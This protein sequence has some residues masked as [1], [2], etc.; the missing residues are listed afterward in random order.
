M[1]AGFGVRIPATL[2]EYRN[3]VVIGSA[4]SELRI[5]IPGRALMG[6]PTGSIGEPRVTGR[7]RHMQGSLPYLS[8]AMDPP[9]GI[10]AG[11]LPSCGRKLRPLPALCTVF[12][13]RYH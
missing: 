13:I 3:L 6:A 5:P 9:P 1:L 10:G 12:T 8:A 7:I 2:P 11:K 4:W